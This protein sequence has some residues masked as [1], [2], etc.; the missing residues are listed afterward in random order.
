MWGRGWN[1]WQGKSTR[2]K[3]VPVLRCPPQIPHYRIW[4]RTRV[5]EVGSQRLTAWATARPPI[6]TDD[7]KYSMEDSTSRAVCLFV[8]PFHSVVKLKQTLQ[9]S[10][11]LLHLKWLY[12]Q[13]V[14][15]LN[16]SCS[17][18]MKCRLLDSKMEFR[19]TAWKVS[20]LR[21]PISYN[22]DASNEWMAS[23]ELF[24]LAISPY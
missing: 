23:A 2:R 20:V 1:D 17:L 7:Q 6:W 4:A 9:T 22:T 14:E 3:P 12:T 11:L 19:S 5:A 18:K 10:L 13:E 21:V 8:I 16:V 24:I 15:S